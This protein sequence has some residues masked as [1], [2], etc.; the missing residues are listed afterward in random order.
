MFLAC[1][2]IL[3][4]A[5]L[6][7]WLGTQN[8]KLELKHRVLHIRYVIFT[9]IYSV[10]GVALFS[11]ILELVN[12]IFSNRI[13]RGIL[14]AFIPQSN[15]P[16]GFYWIT[17]LC[18]CILLMTVYCILLNLLGAIWLKPLSK[19][20]YLSTNNIIEKFFN[21]VS[22]AVYEIIGER[23]ILSPSKINVG[24]WFSIMRKI[25]GAMFL[26]E[27]LFIGLYLQFGFS[28]IGKNVFTVFVKSVYM[29]PVISYI[30]LNQL[31]WFF[32]ADIKKGERLI[33]TE[34]IG[35]T[36]RGSFDKLVEYYEKLFGGKSLISR[37]T[38]NGRNGVQCELLAGVQT[39]QE[40]R[41][42]NP[43]LLNALCRNIQSITPLASGKINE[44]IDL[45]DGMNLAIFSSVFCDFDI[46]YLSYAQYRMALGNTILVL[47]DTEHQVKLMK[48]RYVAV[49]KKMNVAAPVWR[50]NDI[51]SFVDEKTDVLI[52]TE[53]QY[54]HSS[55]IPKH[56]VFFSKLKMVVVVDS[57]GLICRE[58]T[59]FSRLF[60]TFENKDIQYIFYIPENNTDLRNKLQERLNN[61]PISLYENPYFNPET[62]ILFWRS[63]S[64]FKPQLALSSRLYHDFGVAYTIAIVAA[65]QNVPTINILSHESIPTLTYQNLVTKEYEKI[66][67]ED[68]LKNA[69]INLSSVIHNNNYGLV[70]SSALPFNIVYDENNNLLNV[71]RIWLSN[72]D[73]DTSILNI[74]SSPYMLRD[75]FACNISSLCAESTGIQLLVPGK[76]LNLYAPSI[77]LL[78]KMRNG[79]TCNELVR[80]AANYGLNESSTEQILERILCLALGENHHYDV[81]D[82][83]SFKE[84]EVPSFEN[85]TFIYTNLITLI[86]ENLYELI[87]HKT[88]CFVRISGAFNDVLPIPVN[89]VYNHFLPKQYVSFRNVRYV[90][91]DIFNGVL[92]LSAEETVNMEKNYTPLYDITGFEE[93]TKLDG[94]TISSQKLATEFLTAKI[95]RK[96]SAYLSYPGMLM[97]K[98]PTAISLINL[99]SAITEVKTVPCL[100][101]TLKCALEDC[102]NKIAAT[103][104]HL[105]KGALETF[106]PK[107]HKDILVFSKID[108]DAICKNVVFSEESDFL[109]DPIPSDL[110]NGFNVFE[111][112]NPDLRKLFPNVESDDVQPNGTEEIHL[113]IAHFSES[114]IGLITAVADDL[115]RIFS[116]VLTYLNWAEAQNETLSAYLRFG[117]KSTPGIFDS[118]ATISCLSKQLSIKPIPPENA[119]ATI[120]NSSGEYCSFCGN[121]TLVVSHHLNDGRIMCND[122]HNH[123]TSSREEV[124]VLLTEAVNTLESYYGITLPAGIHVK[125]KSA[126]AI[127]KAMKSSSQERVLGFYDSKRNEIWIERGGPK[128][129]V[130]STLVH[131]LTHAWQFE[132]LPVKKYEL[133]HLEGHSSYVEVECMRLMKQN[134]YAE[135]MAKSLLASNNEYGEGYRF[136]ISYLQFETEKNIFKSIKEMF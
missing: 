73:S 96:T 82:C 36:I 114:D 13:V 26:V 33:D 32:A 34:E 59:Y 14:Y 117:Y 70:N 121:P 1:S 118:V 38:G 67:L 61:K 87:C 126:S 88:E 35:S 50:I 3:T 19:T 29:M 10:V 130:M 78:L 54:L 93:K 62:N 7:L 103:L 119:T 42:S 113:Y 120:T 77:I 66:L 52:C 92:M 71:A 15:V 123:T 79:I 56:P 30:I 125:F 16:A 69:A 76:A 48:D 25:F 115:E 28:F 108:H 104:C 65:Q 90:I 39:E 84:C 127:R 5:V 8:A 55:F 18:S 135:F 37:Y 116:T 6:L 51:K 105:L 106:L 22:S 53:E 20:N 102:S 17:T 9:I 41:S 75:Y 64:I 122:C 132:N 128:T 98:D 40:A 80:F 11:K 49:F 60:N 109:P 12:L 57:Y 131:E 111:E 100:H 63:E 112:L 101:I 89:D 44:L 95:T 72:N 74:V 97:F 4:A 83:F 47:C 45:I 81:Y 133:K 107:N 136:W 85:N 46:Y 2:V 21:T 27:S 23:A 110:L 86:D 58:E 68:Y 134:S 94:H 31:E 24:Q 124:K 43:A 91:D 129:C 99:P